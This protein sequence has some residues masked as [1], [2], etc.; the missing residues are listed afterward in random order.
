[1]DAESKPGCCLVWESLGLLLA[2]QMAVVSGKQGCS[3]FFQRAFGNLLYPI[4][5][6]IQVCHAFF[7]STL[8]L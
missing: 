1:M 5:R 2:V 3:C 4:A 7:P 6:E 8:L